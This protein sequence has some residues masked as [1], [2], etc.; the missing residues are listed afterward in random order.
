MATADQYA[1]QVIGIAEYPQ[2]KDQEAQ[3]TDPDLDSRLILAAVT[4]KV[5]QITSQIGPPNTSINISD[6]LQTHL[7]SQL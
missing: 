7:L 3:A 5:V 6:G 4:T 1:D 2:V